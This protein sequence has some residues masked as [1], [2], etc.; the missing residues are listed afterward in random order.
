[1]KNLTIIAATVAAMAAALGPAGEAVA[2]P[3]GSSSASDVVR[4]LQAQGYNVQLNGSVTA[5]LSECMVT[6]VHGD[7][8]GRIVPGQFTTVYVDVSCPPT[9]N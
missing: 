6:G 2:A 4:S 7:S 1:M 8:A 9:N 5:P 3:T